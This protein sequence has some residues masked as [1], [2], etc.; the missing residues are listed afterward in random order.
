MSVGSSVCNHFTFFSRDEVTLYERVS[1]RPLVG[2]LVGWSVTLSL[3]GLLGATYGRV[4][5]L[6]YRNRFIMTLMS[7]KKVGLKDWREQILK[8]K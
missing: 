2:P 3:F 5:L 7:L 8:T 6:M 4:T 1:V